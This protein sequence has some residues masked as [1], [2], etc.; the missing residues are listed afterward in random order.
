MTPRSKENFV[1]TIC[2]TLA[3][4]AWALGKL[5]NNVKERR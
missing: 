4:L 3:L 1:I 2:T 5:F